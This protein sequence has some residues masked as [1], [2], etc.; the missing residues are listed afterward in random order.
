MSARKLR[1]PLGDYCE[2]AQRRIDMKK[3]TLAF[4][5]FIVAAWHGAFIANPSG[6]QPPKIY[7]V[8]ILNPNSPT[9]AGKYIQ[10][11][12]D[13]M[14]RLGYTDANLIVELRYAEGRAERL[15]ELAVELVQSK[16]DVFLPPSE[17]VLLA[18][19]DV[20]GATPIV[21]V[22]C[23]PLE[24]FVGRLSYDRKWCTEMS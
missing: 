21:T 4:C 19:K 10:A 13:E 15:K 8:G 18:A 23:D 2:R 14:R 3:A 6:Q 22:S 16:I 17:P 24:K 11:F 7:R 5:L 1:C 12:R 20:A 9:I